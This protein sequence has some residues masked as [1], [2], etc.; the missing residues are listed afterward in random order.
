M[1]KDQEPVTRVFERLSSKSDPFAAVF[2]PLRPR[3]PQDHASSPGAAISP[4]PAAAALLLPPDEHPRSVTRLGTW[5][6][7]LGSDGVE[8][9]VCHVVS[10]FQQALLPIQSGLGP[11]CNMP[12]RLSPHPAF[13]L[14]VYR[15]SSIRVQYEKT[16]T[17]PARARKLTLPVYSAMLLLFPSGRCRVDKT[18]ACQ[19]HCSSL[20]HHLE[21]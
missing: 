18:A 14:I 10:H 6:K 21:T 1:V 13:Q 7:D 12:V 16:H 3:T 11:P 15:I 9:I 4:L 19:G 20:P 2:F 5:V 17:K 8:A